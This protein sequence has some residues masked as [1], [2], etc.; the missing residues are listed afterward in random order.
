M[1]GV[2]TWFVLADDPEHAWYLSDAEKRLV[3]QRSQMIN[4]QTQSAQI[5]HRTDVIRGLRDWK[6]WTFCAIGFGLDTMLY[7]YSTFLPTIIDGLG[8]WTTAEVQA[9]TIPCYAC[10]AISVSQ[11]SMQM[12]LRRDADRR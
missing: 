7:G 5:M 2:A 3:V 9:L 1:I 11:S 6:V 8:N 10:G 12:I 4:S